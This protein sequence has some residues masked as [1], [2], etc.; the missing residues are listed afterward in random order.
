MLFQLPDRRI[1]SQ[2]HIYGHKNSDVLPAER[3]IS[4]GLIERLLSPTCQLVG[5][6]SQV[7]RH[8]RR[9]SP[10]HALA[11]DSRSRSCSRLPLTRSCCRSRQ[12]PAYLSQ[13]RLALIQN[14]RKQI[15]DSARPAAPCPA[16]RPLAS[17]AQHRTWQWAGPMAL[18]GRTDLRLAESV[19]AT[20]RALRKAGGHPRGISV[21]GMRSDL[22]A[23]LASR[24]GGGLK[25]T[26]ARNALTCRGLAP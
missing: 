25:L 9:A 14:N 10:R 21:P 4:H 22:L 6:E 23:L 16:H 26:F 15:G 12:I 1:R 8:R 17:Q 24:L 19:P 5:A 11:F 7:R 18:G 2:L 20:A 13:A 3:W